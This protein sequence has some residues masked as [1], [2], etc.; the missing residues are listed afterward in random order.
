MS[1]KLALSANSDT[2]APS[3][4]VAAEFFRSLSFSTMFLGLPTLFWPC[5]ESLVACALAALKCSRKSR[6]WTC[7]PQNKEEREEA[8]MITLLGDE[9]WPR[10]KSGAVAC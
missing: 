3:E 4:G 10:Q 5:S 2:E 7:R 1:G 8:C 6:T 9:W